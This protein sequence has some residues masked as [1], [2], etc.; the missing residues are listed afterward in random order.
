ME[1]KQW[2]K[3]SKASQ[4]SL[5]QSKLNSLQVLYDHKWHYTIYKL[6]WQS[7][8]YV[9][10]TFGLYC[11]KW[12]GCFCVW[13][14][15]KMSPHS[16]FLWFPSNRLGSPIWEDTNNLKSNTIVGVIDTGS[17]QSR[18]Q[19][20]FSSSLTFS[21]LLYYSLFNYFAG[22]WPESESFSD[23][24]FGPVPKKFGGQCVAAEN[25]TLVN[26]NR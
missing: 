14:Q 19:F 18:S 4:P 13:K 12:F 22:I 17:R 20:N 7:N 11:R 3:V 15:D 26:G 2:H 16:T 23:K 1:Q 6:K 24:V 10:I 5:H 21:M 8:H 9:F 25:F